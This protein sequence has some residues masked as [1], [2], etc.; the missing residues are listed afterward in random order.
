MIVRGTERTRCIYADMLFGCFCSVPFSISAEMQ[1]YRRYY[2]L[3]FE[4]YHVPRRM[5]RHIVKEVQLH[6]L[7]Y[8]IAM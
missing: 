8:P 2:Y 3:N 7:H 1:L 6:W 4:L 5:L